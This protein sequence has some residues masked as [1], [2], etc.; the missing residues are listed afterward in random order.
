MGS[1]VL[2]DFIAAKRLAAS[3]LTF[4]E[5]LYRTVNKGGQKCINLNADV[6]TGQLY[7]NLESHFEPDTQEIRLGLDI[8][9][10][11]AAGRYHLTR[12]IIKG[13]TYKNWRLNGEFVYDPH[14]EP[15]RF[16]GLQPGDIAVIGF[17]GKPAPFAVRM[18]LLAQ[19]APEDRALH[20]AVGALIPGGRRSMVALT[21][22]NL[23][24]V[25]S[26][27]S[28]RD[29]HPLRLLAL[30]PIAEAAL[31]DAVQG[32]IR[33]TQILR[34]RRKG[35]PVTKAE[36]AKAKRSADATGEAGEELVNDYLCLLKAETKIPNF[37]WVSS[38]NVIAPYDFEILASDG[39]SSTVLIDVKATTGAFDAPFHISM[40]EIIH[41]AEATVPYVIYRVFGLSDAGGQ[42]KVSDDIRAFAQKLRQSHD[43]S[44][45]KQVTA[46]GFTVLVDA[47][48]LS[49]G[50][51][52]NA[53]F[54]AEEP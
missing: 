45:P 12:K 46:D 17:D 19:A 38:E 7:P 39:I 13:G 22:D 47:P 48:G 6:L 34:Q 28:V 25:L 49:W 51:P 41:A 27:P 9:G 52:V 3:D 10:P 14:D 2:P 50:K 11:A 31:E 33:G 26:L 1:T 23:N 54:A 40:A 18:V 20:A 42:I 29:D 5:R 36:L 53:T 32:G 16:D 44:L 15:G 21:Q 37:V 8:Y 43:R 4:F 30:D 35:R 24:K